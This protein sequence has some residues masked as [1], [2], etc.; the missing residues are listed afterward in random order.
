MR[1]QFLAWVGLDKTL[2]S[3]VHFQQDLYF[4]FKYNL[5]DKILQD[6]IFGESGLLCYGLLCLILLCTHF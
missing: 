6:T 4:I 3:E 5:A 1:G 2:K